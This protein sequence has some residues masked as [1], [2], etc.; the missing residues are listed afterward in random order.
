M[1]VW[2]SCQIGNVLFADHQ[3]YSPGQLQIQRG[4]DALLINANSFCN[5]QYGQLKS[6][7]S[8]VLN[9]SCVRRIGTG[10]GTNK[11]FALPVGLSFTPAS[12]RFFFK[13]KG[14]WSG[15]QAGTVAAGQATLTTAP[16]SGA[17][18][19]AD[20]SEGVQSY[21]ESMGSS[22]TAIKVL[23]YRRANDYVYLAGDCRNAYQQQN[24]TA[25][26]AVELIRQV[27]YLRPNVVVVYDR[28]ETTRP[29]FYKRPQWH[30]LPAAKT[31]IAGEFFTV[32]LGGSKLW[33]ETLSLDFITTS[34]ETVL[35]SG[36]NGAVPVQQLRVNITQ[37]AAKARFLTVFQVGETGGQFA[38]PDHDADD[39]ETLESVTLAGWKVEFSREG[40]ATCGVTRV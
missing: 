39:S 36:Q 26:V 25:N 27:V 28:V 12:W 37:P 19:F 20:I 3:S 23:D 8:N 22:G 10:D 2:V 9:I 13:D 1:S 14:L 6:P 29:D 21:P 30:F 38:I 24:G 33:G 18:V 17:E 15:P 7:W 31:S 40:A 4:R 16:P 34:L 5:N 32:E 35:N 11:V